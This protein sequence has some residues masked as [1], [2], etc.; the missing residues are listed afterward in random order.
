MT[1]ADLTFSSCAWSASTCCDSSSILA[2]ASSVAAAP[3]MAASAAASDGSGIASCAVAA[4]GSAG[5][6]VWAI[7]PLP[8][9]SALPA[10][11][12]RMMVVRFMS[13]SPFPASAR[14]ARRGAPVGRALVID[15]LSCL[16]S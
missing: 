11:K 15:Y 9:A 12:A 8:I 5:A 7:A 3:W 14:E 13:S 6:G 1:I 16:K 10:S 4:A 2:C